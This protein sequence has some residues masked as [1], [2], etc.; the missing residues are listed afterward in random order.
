MGSEADALP[1]GGCLHVYHSGVNEN[2]LEKSKN[3]EKNILKNIS[4]NSLKM[5]SEVGALPTS[6]CLQARLYSSHTL[7][8]QCSYKYNATYCCTKLC[9]TNPKMH[10]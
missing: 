5:G 4:D 10:L 6:G 2:I 8:P 1:T 3:A 7:L 9:Y